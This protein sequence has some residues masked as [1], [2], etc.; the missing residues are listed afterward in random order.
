MPLLS[1]S[2]LPRAEG[3]AEARRELGLWL[4]SLREAKGL[5]QRALAQKLD[6]EFYT[7][8]SQIEAGRGRIP[9][10]HYG[11][12]ADAVGVPRKVFVAR[13][14]KCYE[15]TTWDILFGSSADSKDEL[16]TSRSSGS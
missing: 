3:Q 7:F 16:D 10:E 4:R 11:R 9:P 2:R 6:F 14:L 15:P 1:N 12:W 13:L 5:S 8:V